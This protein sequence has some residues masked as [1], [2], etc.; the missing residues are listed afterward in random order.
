METEERKAAA[1]AYAERWSAQIH[2]AMDRMGAC[3]HADGV[4][5][6]SD[7]T[8]LLRIIE[9]NCPQCDLPVTRHGAHGD[10]ACC[11]AGMALSSTEVTLV[12][13]LEAGI[14]Q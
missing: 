11:G 5:D 12:V 8:C 7:A 6:M 14:G 13:H 2:A 4:D 1:A 9:G 3:P 10:C